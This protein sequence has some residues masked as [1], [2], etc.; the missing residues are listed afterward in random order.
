MNK[1]N[2]RIIDFYLGSEKLKRQFSPMFYS[3]PAK[4]QTILSLGL[5]PSLTQNFKKE[6]EARSLDLK[7]FEK[8]SPADQKAKI[9]E[10][11]NYQKELKYGKDSIQYFKLQERFFEEVGVDFR[12]NVFHYDLYQNRETNSKAVLKLLK[13]DK[14]LTGELI[15]Q[16]EDAILLVNPKLILVF[17]AAV[18]KLLKESDQFFKDSETGLDPEMGCYFYNETPILLANQ[19][20][21]GATS[22]VYRDILVW[23]TKKI[24]R[25]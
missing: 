22:I 25:Q 7:S 4:E 2:Q 5:N 19:L 1:I 16:L 17:N 6:L 21:G 13:S 12:K 14:E 11:V 24:L 23:L 10:A 8:A 3:S 9:A 18:S 20:S 15:S